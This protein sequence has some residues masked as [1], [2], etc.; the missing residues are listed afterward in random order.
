MSPDWDISLWYLDADSPRD[1][2]NINHV[3]IGVSTE[4][5]ETLVETTSHT[6]MTPF[7]QIE[8]FSVEVEPTGQFTQEMVEP[9]W[10]PSPTS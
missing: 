8:G 5:A 7:D 1:P 4:S 6:N 9:D 3:M 10:E 2:Q